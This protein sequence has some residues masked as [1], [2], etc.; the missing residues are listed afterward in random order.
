MTLTDQLSSD[1][2]DAM[3]AGDTLRRDTLRMV[4]S[5][6]QNRRIEAGEDLDDGQQLAVLMSAVKSR[7]DSATQYADN[8]RQDLADQELAEIGVIQGYLPKQLGEEETLAIVRTKISELGLTSKKEMGQLM[9]AVMADHKGAA[10]GKLVQ[11]LAGQ[12]R[13]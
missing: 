10:D 1:L 13:A 6:M 3:R 5:A 12:E 8:D 11:R 4:L 2:K 7:T 9:K